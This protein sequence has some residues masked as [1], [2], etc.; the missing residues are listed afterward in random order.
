MKTQAI[1]LILG[2][3]YLSIVSCTTQGL[4]DAPDLTQIK[5]EIQAMEDAFATASN[6]KNAEAVVAYYADDAVSMPN[7][8]TTAT[9]KAAIL[10]LIKGNMAKDTIGSTVVFEVLDIKAAGDLAIEAGKSTSTAANGKV[11]T[12]KYVSIFEKRNG[13]YVCIRD[14]YNNDA[15]TGNK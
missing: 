10:E 5:A 15:P 4:S 14:I 2:I 8:Q 11:T 9:G 1:L 3:L 7:D 13:K 6:A 12:G